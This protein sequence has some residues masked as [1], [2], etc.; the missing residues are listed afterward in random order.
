MLMA[1]SGVETA[2]RS[3]QSNVIC[4]LVAVVAAVGGGGGGG[5]GSV[6]N[7]HTQLDKQPGGRLRW[8]AQAAG[9]AARLGRTGANCQI[10]DRGGDGTSKPAG[11]VGGQAR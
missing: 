5:C 9:R 7:E 10:S 8:L 6:G 3:I 4:Q 11:L 2:S 1:R